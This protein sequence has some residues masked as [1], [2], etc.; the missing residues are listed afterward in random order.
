MLTQGVA[1]TQGSRIDTAHRILQLLAHL[2]ES[3][4]AIDVEVFQ[5][6]NHFDGVLYKGVTEYFALGVAVGVDG[7]LQSLGHLGEYVMQSLPCIVHRA[8][9]TLIHHGF[10]VCPQLVEPLAPDVHTEVAA[11]RQG[12]HAVAEAELVDDVLPCRV[13]L[14]VEQ[15]AKLECRRA[16]HRVVLL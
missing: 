10:V 15:V 7:V 13:V 4:I 16:H 9:D 1:L 2:F 5:Q 14:A 6:P 8:L 12:S 11:R 3:D